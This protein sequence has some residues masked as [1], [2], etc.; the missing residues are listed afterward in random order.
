MA[1]YYFRLLLLFGS[2]VGVFAIIGSLLPRG[3]DFQTE[4][5][6]AA[7][8]ETIFPKINSLKNWQTWSKQFSPDEIEGLEI[9]YNGD[10]SGVGAAQSWSDGRGDGKLWITESQPNQSVSFDMTFGSF[11]TMSSQIELTSEPNP[12]KEE[13]RTTK[14]IWS[15]KGTLPGGPFYGY[16]GSFFGAQMQNQYD[17]SLEKLKSV[18]EGVDQPKDADQPKAKQEQPK[19]Q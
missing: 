12:D 13:G 19:S 2:V 1:K 18:V 3:Y 10:E 9:K 16:F 6:I 7:A 5:D 14:V 8:P 17:K 15:S 11:P 4:I